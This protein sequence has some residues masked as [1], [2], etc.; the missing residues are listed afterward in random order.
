MTNSARSYRPKVRRSSVRP[1]VRTRESVSS[2]RES[3]PW[4]WCRFQLGRRSKRARGEGEKKEKKSLTCATFF[5]KRKKSV[6]NNRDLPSK[7]TSIFEH[8]DGFRMHGPISSFSW[9]IWPPGNLNKA[10]VEA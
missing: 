1:P 9:P 7:Q 3:R 6:F 5:N 2:L 4:R 8:G 10:I